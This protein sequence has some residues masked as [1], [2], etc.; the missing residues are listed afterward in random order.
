MSSLQIVGKLPDAD[1]SVMLKSSADSLDTTLVVDTAYVTSQLTNQTKNL[2]KQDYVDQQDA[3]RGHKTD[4]DAADRN[5]LLQ[6]DMGSSLAV[7][8]GSGNVPAS[9][10]PSGIVLSR[11]PFSYSVGTNG[12]IYLG[13]G[14]SQ[15]VATTNYRELLIAKMVIA[16]PGYPWYPLCFGWVQGYASGLDNG[17]FYGNS[18]YGLLTVQ[19]PSGVSDTLY[20]VGVG[21]STVHPNYVSLVPSCPNNPPGFKPSQQPAINGSLELDLSG[22]CFTGS[23]YVWTGANLVWIVFVMPSL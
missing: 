17:R 21:P 18:N 2:V 3:L 10:I 23:G 5:Y 16:D 14:T 4:V 6:T 12:T 1:A 7:L 11:L 8:D 20:A 15:S 9:E 19:P 13:Q 22:C